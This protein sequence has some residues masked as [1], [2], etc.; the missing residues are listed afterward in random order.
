MRGWDDDNDDYERAN[1][2][3]LKDAGLVKD[4]R[5]EKSPIEPAVILDSKRAERIPSR[6]RDASADMQS[7]DGRNVRSLACRKQ[8]STDITGTEKGQN[9]WFHDKF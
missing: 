4:K 3:L 8:A 7:E 6:E 9:K 1:K 5:R 2:R